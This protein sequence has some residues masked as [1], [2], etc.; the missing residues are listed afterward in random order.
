MLGWMW[1]RFFVISRSSSQCSELCRQLRAAAQLSAT[2][3]DTQTGQEQSYGQR[4]LSSR[5]CWDP[6]TEQQSWGSSA[7]SMTESGTRQLWQLTDWLLLQVHARRH[8]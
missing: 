5:H 7:P 6:S 3:Q 1:S 2:L 8:H 4:S